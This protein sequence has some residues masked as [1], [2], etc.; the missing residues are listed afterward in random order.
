MSK[1]SVRQ[2]DLVSSLDNERSVQHKSLTEPSVS[3]S[4]PSVPPVVYQHLSRLFQG[5]V[6]AY[7]KNVYNSTSKDAFAVSCSVHTRFFEPY[8]EEYYKGM[9]M[10]FEPEDIEV[11]CT[12]LTNERFIMFDD[13]LKTLSSVH[14]KSLYEMCQRATGFD[15]EGCAIH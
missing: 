7:T 8:I 4:E 6:E 13:A 12:V 1:S 2:D 5:L 14:S 11:I 9:L 3:T 15:S 10:V